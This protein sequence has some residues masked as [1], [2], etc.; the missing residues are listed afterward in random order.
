MPHAAPGDLLDLLQAVA[1][2]CDPGVVH[3]SAPRS[4]SAP[5]FEECP[6]AQQVLAQVD[7]VVTGLLG[8]DPGAMLRWRVH[9]GQPTGPGG[10]FREP[11]AR[12]TP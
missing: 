11:G 2:G 8:V 12:R 7:L 10:A 1:V 9:A 5:D 4:E 3:P 6:V